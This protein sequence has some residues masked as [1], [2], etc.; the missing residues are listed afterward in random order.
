MI[1]V[2][3]ALFLTSR[4][5]GGGGGES[6]VSIIYIQVK[7]SIIVMGGSFD[8]SAYIYNLWVHGQWRKRYGSNMSIYIIPRGSRHT[9]E[10]YFTLPH[11][12]TSTVYT[13]MTSYI[14]L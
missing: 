7:L 4:G 12:M 6:V 11:G 9:T 1:K 14:A 8:E 13:H 5:W 10:K 3:I 2:Y